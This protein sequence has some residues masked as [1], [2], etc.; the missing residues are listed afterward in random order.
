VFET[1]SSEYPVYEHPPAP[2]AD[3][4]TLVAKLPEILPEPETDPASIFEETSH[5][6]YDE[7]SHVDSPASG[8]SSTTPITSTQSLENLVATHQYDEALR[9]LDELLQFDSNIPFSPLYE[10]AALFAVRAPVRTK[11]E[12]DEQLKTFRKWFSLIPTRDQ[13]PPRR[14]RKLL[15][16]ITFSSLTSLRLLMEFG[17]ITTEKGYGSI[18]LRHVIPVVAM[19]G[20]PQTTLQFINEL[21]QRNRSFVEESAKPAEA[22]AMDRKL[23][24]D[25]LGAAIRSLARAGLFDHATS[26]IPDPETS[27]VHLTAHTYNLLLQRMKVAGDT[28]YIP[29]I[30]HVM[31][32]RAR[33]KR[34]APQ[35]IADRKYHP[36]V[37]RIREL[38]GEIV[39]AIRR[40][41]VKLGPEDVQMASLLSPTPPEPIRDNLVVLLR[42][43]KK[44]LKA[45]T[46]SQ[47][48]H[49]VNIVRFFELY[50]AAGRTHA[51]PLLRRLALRRPI[52]GSLFTYSEMLFH[53]RNFNP[54]LAIH[55][56][57]QRFY[58]VGLPR[59]EIIFQLRIRPL[60]DKERY[61]WLGKPVREKFFP[62]PVHAALVWHA[63]LALTVKDSMLQLLYEKLLD[64]A[65]L[66]TGHSSTLHPGI[67]L[68]PPPPSWETGTSAYAFTPFVRRIANA[69]G[70][71]RAARI[72]KDM[73]QLGL[74]P[75]IFQLTELAMAYARV[76]D[77]PKTFIMLDQVESAIP[78]WEQAAADDVDASSAEA[79]ASRRQARSQSGYLIPPVDEVFYVAIARGFLK[80]DQLNAAREVQRRMS[81]RYKYEP[82]LTPTSTASTTT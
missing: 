43:I 19:Y 28:R 32:N 46:K 39:L 9:L 80:S 75:N 18:T 10:Q 82:G 3:V 41:P 47:M 23:H 17:L 6:D 15:H 71:E 58:I 69:F 63:L 59:D 67:P 4:L 34:S 77:V 11:S 40:D 76:G 36:A 27:G 53:V 26:L 81:M 20:D 2:T 21:R 70:T 8:I 60:T 49:A 12:A 61:L 16:I 62:L 13:S 64:F 50:D 31:E 52:S 7:I 78:G 14:F 56:F 48:P 33:S 35:T 72:L 79:E 65:N 45:L 44:G 42:I 54:T 24:V 57:T 37:E 29:H 30:Q 51:I 1:P 38:R 5:M 73:M 25:T 66:R 55:T 68:L 74:K 22:H